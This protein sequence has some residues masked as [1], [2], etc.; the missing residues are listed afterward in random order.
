MEGCPWVMDFMEDIESDENILEKLFI[1]AYQKKQVEVIC[2]TFWWLWFNRNKVLHDHHCLTMKELG[3][4]VKDKSEGY[5]ANAAQGMVTRQ[6]RT[7][8]Q[9]LP[10]PV[11]V[12]KLNVDA[13]Y[14][15]ITKAAGLG[16]VARNDQ[17][18]VCLSAVA[19]V[20]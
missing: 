7:D 16:I 13:S 1:K 11:G 14:D 20:T 10:P 19:K 12:I 8:I 6:G 17:G 15:H 3:R 5:H 4:R 18:E 2:V 9:W